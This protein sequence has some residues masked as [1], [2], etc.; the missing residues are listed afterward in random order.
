MP[1]LVIVCH[2]DCVFDFVA[3]FLLSSRRYCH[4]EN[5]SEICGSKRCTENRLMHLLTL[6]VGRSDFSNHDFDVHKD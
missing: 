4:H 5:F 2:S 3:V 1:L 6:L